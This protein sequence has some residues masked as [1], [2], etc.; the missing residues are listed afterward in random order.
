MATECE[1]PELLEH[2]KSLNLTNEEINRFAT[3]FKEPQF[4]EMFM[5]Y[6]KEISDSSNKETM[7]KHL[8]QCEQN[9]QGQG[10][11]PIEGKDLLLP[12][13]NFCIKTYDIKTKKKVFINFCYCN[14]II[15]CKSCE[16]PSRNG[17]QWEIPYS[18]GGPSIEKDKA[19]K[20]CIVYDFIVG[21]K[22]RDNAKDS[23]PFKKFLILTA[24]EA[25]EKQK[26]IDLEKNYSQPLMKYKG[27]NGS[28]EP[29]IFT[30]RKEGSSKSLKDN[31]DSKKLVKYTSK[32]D[33]DK[34]KKKPKINEDKMK[35][36]NICRKENGSK[37]EIVNDPSNLDGSCNSNVENDKDSKNLEEW[38]TEIIP[39][40]EVLYSN[41]VD[42]S[43]YWADPKVETSNT[44][45]EAIVLCIALPNIL[46]AQDVLVDLEINQVYL[47][48]PGKYRLKVDLK[49][50]IDKLRSQ[51]QWKKET[52][53]L[54]ITL[55]VV[56]AVDSKI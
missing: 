37:K 1:A 33:E 8:K 30:I 21:D 32:I 14:K 34:I 7:E 49:Y 51:A 48:V 13:T 19:G 42:Y 24:I 54:V 26:H 35:K 4:K 6:I 39:Q 53:K 29:R 45:P 3:S 52:H 18:L 43:K 28:K 10:R 31:S 11:S 22:T 25:L 41:T 27:K 20:E 40:Y 15:D 36:E 47:R 38:K 46:H 2:I 44:L 56:E 12:Y 50:N 23:K 9:L 55:P 16:D 17:T 5:N